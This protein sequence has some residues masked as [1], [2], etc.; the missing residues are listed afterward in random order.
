MERVLYEGNTS[1]L[2]AIGERMLRA[3][4]QDAC[5]APSDV[6]KA[7]VPTLTHTT[8]M[9]HAYLLPPFRPSLLLL[10]SSL[11]TM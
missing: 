5:D 10:F 9:S 4:V 11:T 7:V 1:L 2:Q 3:V 6:W 8:R